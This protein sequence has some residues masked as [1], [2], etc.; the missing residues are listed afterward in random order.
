MEGR[1][2]FLCGEVG[3]YGCHFD[4]LDEA[5]TM[6]REGGRDGGE[7]RRDGGTEGGSDLQ[8]C[9]EATMEKMR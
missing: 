9:E 8:C 2:T 3:T 4:G 5:D 6:V 7:G 1:G